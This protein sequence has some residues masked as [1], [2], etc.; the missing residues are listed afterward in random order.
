[1]ILWHQVAPT[2]S[3]KVLLLGTN[4]TLPKMHDVRLKISSGAMSQA[5]TLAPSPSSLKSF[6]KECESA[7]TTPKASSESSS[8]SRT[9]QPIVSSL[10]SKSGEERQNEEDTIE[11]REDGTPYPTRL[12]LGIIVLAICMS[13]LLMG[14]E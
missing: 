11:T 13:I 2:T 8:S 12:K 3:R 5:P 4:R 1:M 14:L 9:V 7:F 6:E 10:S